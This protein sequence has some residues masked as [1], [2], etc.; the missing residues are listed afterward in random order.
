MVDITQDELDKMIE[1]HKLWLKNKERGQRLELRNTNLNG[2]ILRNIDLSYSTFVNVEMFKVTI[3][4]CNV[5]ASHLHNVEIYRTFI[6]STALSAS[7]LFDVKFNESIIEDTNLTCSNLYKTN[8]FNCKL[9]KVC[10]KD[11][12]LRKVLLD[13]NSIDTTLIESAK[14][15]DILLSNN[16]LNDNIIQI[17][18]IGSRKAYTLY[19]VDKDNVRCGCWKE[20]RGGTLEEFKQEVE[21]TYPDGKYHDEYMMAIETF[22]KSREL[23]LKSKKENE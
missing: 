19:F 1:N 8:F 13:C 15:E 22:K 5:Y 16:I 10:L 2:L 11:I 4:H 6:Y 20:Y 14:L 3:D 7:N 18:P 23:Y 17:G 12:I 21:K 9:T